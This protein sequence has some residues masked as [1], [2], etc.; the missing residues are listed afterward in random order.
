MKKI[1]LLF[2]CI[3]AL[4]LTPSCD[5]DNP[6]PPNE[7]ELITTLVVTFVDSLSAT[8]TVRLSFTDLDGE[9]GAAPVLTADDFQPNTT[10]NGSIVL[11]DQSKSPADNI[12]EEVSEEA[13]EHQFFYQPTPGSL[14]TYFQYL[15]SDL[16]GKPV[17][18]E[19]RI[20]TGDSGSGNLTVVLRH[21]P[22]KFASGVAS[23]D[24]SLAGGETDAEVTFPLV[25]L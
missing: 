11:L 9:G 5:K 23:G 3:A 25:V 21:E 6:T 8:D 16:N 24:I 7:S 19:F 12:T 18:I 13:D 2:S 22:D 4:L 15:D 14:V 20:R 1:A 10:Y 17:G